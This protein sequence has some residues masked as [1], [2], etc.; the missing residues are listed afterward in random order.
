MLRV[1]RRLAEQ[2]PARIRTTFL[3]HVIPPEYRERPDAYVDLICLELIPQ[4]ARER[5]AE[6]V[7]V[8][9]ESIAFSLEQT[10]RIFASAKEWGLGI[11]V[12][13]EQLSSSGA[14]ALAAEYGAWS[15]DH[16]EYLDEEGVI[17]LRAA[18]TVATLLPGAFYFLGETH[19]P[20]VELLRRYGVPIA[21][22]TDLNPGTSPLASLRLMMNMGCTLFGLTPEESLIAVTRNAARA[23]GLGETLGTLSVGK[24]ADMLLWDIEH[25]AQL[26]AEVG[27]GRPRQRI[28]EGEIEY[29]PC[30]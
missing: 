27:W 9:C 22:A 6:A 21:L 30:S 28:F 5:L 7:D 23:L 15:A 13:G 19:K 17:A 16:L 24:R 26:A 25:P 1:A 3:A 4:V 8:F 2:V 18:G 10:R 12:H 14:A 11:R 20:P 29:A